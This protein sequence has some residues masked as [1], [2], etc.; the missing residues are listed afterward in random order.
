MRILPCK[1][2]GL[3]LCLVLFSSPAQWLWDRQQ[4]YTLHQADS[5]RVLSPSPGD[6]VAASLWSIKETF[7]MGWWEELHMRWVPDHDISSKIWTRNCLSSWVVTEIL[8]GVYSFRA[9]CIANKERSWWE[10]LQLSLFQQHTWGMMDL[11]SLRKE[12]FLTTLNITKP[13]ILSFL[14]PTVWNIGC[15]W[16]WEG[17]NSVPWRC[18]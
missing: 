5:T 12:K 16:R 10:L 7:C 18:L 8:T 13:S 3:T 14:N 2:G 1:A 17:K 15:A 9:L 4:Q 11:L 6:M